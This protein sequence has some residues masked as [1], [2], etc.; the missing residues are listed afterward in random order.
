MRAL[1]SVI[2][3]AMVS[4]F[5]AL[6]AWL[7]LWIGNVSFPFV[8]IVGIVMSHHLITVS[9]YTM[10]SMAKT[11]LSSKYNIIDFDKWN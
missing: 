9:A 6:P 11:K 3:Y 8:S 10:H 4:C 2:G 7:A 1:G 5:F